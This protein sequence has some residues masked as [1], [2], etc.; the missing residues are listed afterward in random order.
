MDKNAK[1]LSESN[2]NDSND[3]EIIPSSNP[4]YPP[5]AHNS[6]P[7]QQ[8]I[9][10]ENDHSPPVAC[11]TN[12]STINTTHSVDSSLQKDKNNDNPTSN[13]KYQQH[14]ATM[15][16]NMTSKKLICNPDDSGYEKLITYWYD[17]YYDEVA[18]QAKKKGEQRLKQMT[19]KRKLN[20][21][22]KWGKA[23]NNNV[24]ACYDH[25]TMSDAAQDIN[26]I[27][28]DQ[29]KQLHIASCIWHVTK[30]MNIII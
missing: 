26:D 30:K 17:E 23:S 7:N 24:E 28:A 20:D 8:T 9:T 10:S 25:T 12:Q 5:N 13:V 14:L 19:T 18:N 16:N 6:S 15:Q 29:E 21:H 2:T 22:I 4:E 27:K 11:S 3:D 1:N